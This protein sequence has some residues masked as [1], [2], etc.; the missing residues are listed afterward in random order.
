MK[1]I[2]RKIRVWWWFIINRPDKITP[3]A[4]EA[5]QKSI[6]EYKNIPF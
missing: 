6:D 4:W 2:W 5:F 1:R 3:E